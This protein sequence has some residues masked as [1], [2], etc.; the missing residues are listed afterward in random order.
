MAKK[1]YVLYSRRTLDWEREFNFYA[2]GIKEAK[3]F[4]YLWADREGID[5]D[6]IGIRE[7]ARSAGY[8]IFVASKII[9]ERI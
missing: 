9:S 8:P 4:A 6:H 3:F 2:S 7:D 1:I 5:K